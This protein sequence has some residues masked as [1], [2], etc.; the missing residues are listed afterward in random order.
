MVLCISRKLSQGEMKREG[1]RAFDHLWLSWG[2]FLHCR[3][4]RAGEMV[5]TR[6]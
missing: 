2:F 5:D 3:C 1:T 4:W 6:Q